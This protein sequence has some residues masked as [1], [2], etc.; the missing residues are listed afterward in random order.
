MVETL[1]LASLAL[2]IENLVGYPRAFYDRVG[3]PV[4]W[5]GRLITALENQLNRPADSD[6]D[7]RW[8]GVLAVAALIV[9][10][11]VPALLLQFGL[12]HLPFGWLINV[13]LATTLLAQKSLRDHVRAV[14]FTLGVSLENARVET[15]KIVGRDVRTL[16]ESGLSK[17]ALESLAENA[18]DGIV[19]PAL[20]YGIFGL[21]GLVF[22]KVI[23]TADSMIGH[24]SERY[25]QFGWA[26]A[27]LDDLINLPGSRL[28]GL[29]FAAAARF[30]SRE[31]ARQSLSAMR[32]D[33][34]LHQSPNAGWPEA[35]MAG[36]LGLKF[37]GPRQYDGE[38]VNL[39]YMGDGRSEMGASDI[40]CGLRMFERSMIILAAGLFGLAVVLSVA[41]PFLQSS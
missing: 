8:K 38:Q 32:R 28:C 20:W 11:V 39:P 26:A 3:H 34:R 14:A 29:L 1:V 6:S 36:A 10:T 27:R 25:F 16:D 2:W 33:A 18:S 37:G 41:S 17:A 35:A 23:N 22:Y 19:A 5:I 21:P 9:V 7:R 31:A 12:A 40:E 15:A 4:E 30:T 13:F 24:K